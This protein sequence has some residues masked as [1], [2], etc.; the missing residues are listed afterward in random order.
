MAGI[1]I[2]MQRIRKAPR[3]RDFSGEEELGRN[4]GFRYFSPN[5]DLLSKDPSEPIFLSYEDVGKAFHLAEQLYAPAVISELLVLSRDISSQA[6]GLVE[7]STNIPSIFINDSGVAY[8]RG[9][10]F[11]RDFDTQSKLQQQFGGS[12]LELETRLMPAP[13]RGGMEILMQAKELD[14]AL[15]FASRGEE[16]GTAQG[17]AHL[18][19]GYIPKTA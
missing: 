1:D 6:K 13:N 4:N 5:L 3:P 7:G 12:N 11:F 8:I 2:I 14:G 17:Y 10:I 19:L 15:I 16:W 18:C 9:G